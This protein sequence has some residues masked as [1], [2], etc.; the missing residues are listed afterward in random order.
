MS[1][2]ESE[3]RIDYVEFPATDL[4][5]TKR[6][7]Q[8]VF[9]WSFQDWGPTYTAFDD[10]RLSGGFHAAENVAAGGP[11]VILYAADLEAMRAAVEAAGG[12]IVVDIFAF[13]GGRRFHFSDPNGNVLAVWSDT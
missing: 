5:A 13:P 9:G 10:G 2:T 7:F 6:F 8:T 1:R 12:S 11:L 3:R 4:E